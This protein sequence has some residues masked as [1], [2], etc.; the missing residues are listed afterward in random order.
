MRFQFSFRHMD[1]SIPLRTYAEHKLRDKIQKF[2]AR[3]TLVNVCFEF[4]RYDH[5][6]HCWVSG[7]DGRRY[8]AE[9]RSKVDFYAAMDELVEKLEMQLRRH[10][11]KSQVRKFKHWQDYIRMLERGDMLDHQPE[12]MDAEEILRQEYQASAG[13]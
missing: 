3:A 9:N 10:K 12:P 4:D 6:V 2:D 5:V 13:T 11:E 8:L 7:G 1:A